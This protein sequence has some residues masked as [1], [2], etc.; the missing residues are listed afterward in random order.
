MIRKIVVFFILKLLVKFK[1]KVNYLGSVTW[2][3]KSE[4][5]SMNS[6][7]AKAL[8]GIMGGVGIVTLPDDTFACESVFGGSLTK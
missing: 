4:G 7:K 3:P 2:F 8:S 1:N 6:F 5:I